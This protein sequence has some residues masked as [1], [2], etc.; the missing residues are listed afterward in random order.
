M[1]HFALAG[2]LFFAAGCMTRPEIALNY[3]KTQDFSSFK[4]FVWAEEKPTTVKGDVLVPKRA[5][6]SLEQAVR[7]ELLEKGYVEVQDASKA[8]FEVGIVLSVNQSVAI[9]AM[10]RSITVPEEASVYGVDRVGR[11]PDTAVVT[12]SGSQEIELN[13]LARM[14]REATLGIEIYEVGSGDLVWSVSAERDVTNATFD[15]DNVDRAARLLLRDF[16]P[17]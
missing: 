14:T 9:D 6:T 15:G 16:P 4:T 3:D 8:D 7:D 11:R 10:D 17:Q 12:R 2:M 13:P 1:R 5:I